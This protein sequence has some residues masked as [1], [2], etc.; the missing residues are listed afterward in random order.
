MRPRS[1]VFDLNLPDVRGLDGLIRI[2]NAAEDVPVII[3]SSLD[4]NR[5]HSGCA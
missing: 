5:H 2:R 1:I 4:D 3:V